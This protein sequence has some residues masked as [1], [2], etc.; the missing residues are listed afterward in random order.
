MFV[1]VEYPIGAEF[2]EMII[3]E[4][5]DGFPIEPVPFDRLSVVFRGGG[6]HLPYEALRPLLT[7]SL[8]P[9]QLRVGIWRLACRL[10][11]EA[12]QRIA[13]ALHL[14]E[15]ISYAVFCHPPD[16]SLGSVRRFPCFPDEAD[17][18]IAHMLSNVLL[19]VG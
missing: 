12:I 2:P 15:V 10:L 13:V 1:S 4:G 14:A 6:E 5:L 9:E 7:L 8:Q 18:A 3:H 17:K 11:R 16:E 19:Q